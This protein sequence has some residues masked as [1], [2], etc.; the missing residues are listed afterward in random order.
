[1][2]GEICVMKFIRVIFIVTCLIF[3]N[4]VGAVTLFPDDPNIIYTGVVEKI[5]GSSG[6]ELYRLKKSYIDA[7]NGGYWSNKNAGTQPGISIVIK[8]ASPIVRFNFSLNSAYE[9]RWARVVLYENGVE[10]ETSQGAVGLSLSISGSASSSGINTWTCILPAFKAQFLNNIELEDGYTLESPDFSSK[11]VYV[12]IGNSITHGVGQTANTTTLGYAWQVAEALGYELYNFA[13]GGSKI[14][15]QILDNFTGISPD[16]VSVLWG[17]NDVNSPWDLSQAMAKFDT[18]MTSLVQAYPNTK[19]VAIEQTYTTTTTGSQVP[20]NSIERLRTEELAILEKLQLTHKNLFI[21]NGLDYTDATS[22]SDAV[23]L[24]DQGAKD[25]ANGL[26]A[27]IPTFKLDDYDPLKSDTTVFRSEYEKVG[28]T[29]FTIPAFKSLIADSSDLLNVTVSTSGNVIVSSEI[30]DLKYDIHSIAIVAELVSGDTIRI[31]IVDGVDYWLDQHGGVAQGNHLDMKTNGDWATH[32]NLWGKGTAIAGTDFR[33]EMAY[34]DKLPDSTLIVWDVPGEASEFGGSS[35]WNYSNLIWGNRYGERDDLA[36]FPY[37]LDE[38]DSLILDFDYTTIYDVEGHKVALNMFTTEVDT[39]APFDQNRGDFFMVFDQKGTWVPNYP[40]TLHSG[41][42]TTLL[43]AAYCLMHKEDI[44]NGGPYHLRRAIIKNSETVEQGQ[45]DLMQLFNL[46][47]NYGYIEMDLS[48]PNIQFG[49]E[50]TNGLGAIRV[51]KLSI[52][53]KDSGE[54]SA[55]LLSENIKSGV[56]IQ[57]RNNV[58]I[59]NANNKSIKRVNVVNFQG[60][61]LKSID[62]S[63]STKI[64]VDISDLSLGV[65]LYQILLTGGEVQ[66]SQFVKK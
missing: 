49:V 27:E 7:S 15:T 37:R 10:A 40:D 45:I 26:I 46:F 6:M 1:M 25:L 55:L 14:N 42:D 36:G 12:A 61:V 32:N 57:N 31:I 19:I 22:L 9:D 34:T 58:L 28:D 66:F 5:N 51:N 17:Y 48:V 33:I 29:L 52:T 50:V 54:T 60:R 62:V 64:K 2:P 47:N 56:N 63:K 43:G 20:E 13:V 44:K 39:L 41:T 18:L 38:Y 8:T 53:P 3:T 24:N 4:I 16:L 11:P 30:V 23:H 21:V 65:Y 35:V 59:L